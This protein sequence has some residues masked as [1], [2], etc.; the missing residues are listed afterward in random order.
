MAGLEFWYEFASTYSYPAAMRIERMAADAGIGVRWRPFLLGPI[1][2]QQWL[3][4]SPFNANAAKC[5][6]MWRDL[7]RICAAEGCRSLCR[8]SASRKA[9]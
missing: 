5:R 6:Y 4:D 3:N 8:R 9:G 7:T 1:F 2:K